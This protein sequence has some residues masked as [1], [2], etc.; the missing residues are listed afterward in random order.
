MAD[1]VCTDVNEADPSKDED[2]EKPGCY[3]CATMRSQCLPD[4]PGFTRPNER[5]RLARN[6][7]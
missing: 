1:D 5:R 7:S 2:Y 3:G 6:E 4:C